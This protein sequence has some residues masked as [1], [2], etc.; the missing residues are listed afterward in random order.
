MMVDALSEE[1]TPVPA[2]RRGPEDDTV[3][4]DPALLNAA[5]KEIGVT[6]AALAEAVGIS[7]SMVSHLCRGRTVTCRRATGE[8]IEDALGVERGSL[9]GDPDYETL[10]NRRGARTLNP[11][12]LERTIEKKQK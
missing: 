8:A 12:P 2:P 6:Y 5:R 4:V 7:R 10:R 3:Q 11:L 1:R 9:F